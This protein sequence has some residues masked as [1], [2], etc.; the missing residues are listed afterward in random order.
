VSDLSQ[1]F[2]S[3]LPVEVKRSIPKTLLTL[4]GCAGFTG[5]GIW[6]LTTRPLTSQDLLVGVLCI[7]FFGM[8]GLVGVYMLFDTRP[9]V[10]L[11]EQGVWVRG[12]K[13]CPIPWSDVERVWKY[14]QRVGLAYGGQVEIDYVCLSLK[15]AAK[16]RNKQGSIA[17]K[18]ASYCRPRGWGDIYFSTKATNTSADE[19]V[20]AIQSHIGGVHLSPVESLFSSASAS[21]PDA[22]A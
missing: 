16:L 20:A 7:T 13:G 10:L 3:S 12:W 11:N 4:L 9:R 2:A 14:E 8:G 6:S 19:L 1:L 15:H 18:F 21:S 17:R 22:G 5:I